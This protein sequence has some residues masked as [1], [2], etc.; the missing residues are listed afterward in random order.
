MAGFG[1]YCLFL[2]SMLINRETWKTYLKRTVDECLSVGIDSIF[3]VT[4][5]S[6]FVGAVTGMQTAYNMKSLLVPK[7]FISFSVRQMTFLELAP[8]L[9][10]LVFTGKVG[11]NIASELGSMRITEQIDALEVMGINTPSY[12][13]LPKIIATVLMYPLL[14][15]LSGFLSL[16]GGY[17]VCTA[18]DLVSSEAYISGLQFEFDPYAIKFAIYKALV[19]AFLIASISAYQ[20][21]HTRGG[22]LQVGK[23]STYAVTKSCI[24]LLFADAILAHL[25]LLK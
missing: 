25:L 7:Y 3:I 14:V 16:Y 17:I 22:A 15:I 19:F 11:S 4:L 10:G 5:I 6:F 8:S 24:A 1:K 20:G 2:Y 23:S 9:I 18:L 12:L 13:V 21:F